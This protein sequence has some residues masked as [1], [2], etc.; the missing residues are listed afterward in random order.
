MKNSFLSLKKNLA[1]KIEENPKKELYFFDE[2]R[3]GT[4]SKV[5]YGW[6]P[7][8]IRTSVSV[9]LGFENFYVYS[10]VS[11]KTG[12]DCSLLMPYVNSTCMNVF[13][14]HMEQELDG[15]EILLVMDGAGWHK[16]KALIVPTNI[17]IIYL[18]PYSPELN[19]VE[20]LW[21]Y[22]KSHI[23]KNKIY[24][25]INDLEDAV[26]LFIKGFNSELI[27]KTCST[28]HFLC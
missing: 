17:K 7:K 28:N 14:D 10:A 11:P 4:H 19:P 12:K 9:K 15:E 1:K 16:S 25:N 22:M 3:F 8:G 2:S 21:Q 13:L 20:K 27:K 6:F 26:C 23:I 24:D 18:S 5:G